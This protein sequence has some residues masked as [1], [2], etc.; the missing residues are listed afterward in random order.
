MN[1]ERTGVGKEIEDS[2]AGRSFS[3]GLS[4]RSV[5]KKK[6]D[7]DVIGEID[8]EAK[9]VF[10]DDLL[11]GPSVHSFVLISI[12]VAGS[13]A[14]SMLHVQSFARD[15]EPGEDLGF[16]I[17]AVFDLLLKRVILLSR[18]KPS[19]RVSVPSRISGAGISVP[20]D[21]R[22]VVGHVA[23]VE[24]EAGDALFP[25]PLGEVFHTV[26][27]AFSEHGAKP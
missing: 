13:L 23:F 5:I 1:T 16:G 3:D 20:V 12:A 8:L 11:C 2:L 17:T 25:T 18:M 15:V 7:V 9:P 26:C 4:G 6:T 21:D 19:D 24:S 10:I 22:G 27:E 14:A